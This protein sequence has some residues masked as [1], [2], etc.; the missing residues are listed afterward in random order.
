MTKVVRIHEHG[1]PEVLQVEDLALADPGPGEVLLRNQAVGLNFFDTYQ[2]TGIYPIDLPAALGTESAG[3]IEAVG[4]EVEDLATG[5]R[6]YNASQGSYCEAMVVPAENLTRLPDDVDA[7]D[8]AAA[9]SKAMTVQALVES[10]YPVSAGDVVLWHAAAGGVGLIACQWLKSM[11]VRV[12]GTVSSDEKADL[13]RANGCDIALVVPRD[14]VVACVMSE[15]GGDGVPVVF[16]SVGQDSF[17]TSLNSL[18]RRG[19]MVSFGQAS[20]LVEPFRP[21]ILAAHRSLYLTRPLLDDFIATPEDKATCTGRVFEMMTS[22]KVKIHIGQ[23][24]PLA[25]TAQAHRDLEGRK[26]KGSTVLI[27]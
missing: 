7:S 1:G 4:P 22:G 21:N 16:D 27:P 6:V 26:T 25:D 5:D 10:C 2:R 12:I 23:T 19:M 14:D 15:T 24:Y 18:C 9:M 17:Q 13:A 3:V 20:G 11:G 8:A